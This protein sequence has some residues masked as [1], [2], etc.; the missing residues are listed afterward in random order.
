MLISSP[1][2]IYSSLI[3]LSNLGLILFTWLS[4]I[5]NK[6]IVETKNTL[7][8]LECLCIISV[9]DMACLK[10]LCFLHNATGEMAQVNDLFILA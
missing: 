8:H 9:L 4:K 3:V 5:Q 1:N 2:Q 6:S 7:V 10:L